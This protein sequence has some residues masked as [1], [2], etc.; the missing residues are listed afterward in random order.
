MSKRPWRTHVRQSVFAKF[1]AIMLT[2]A[3]SLLVLVAGFVLL[4]LRPVLNASI[5]PVL[6]EY[7][8][9]V[10]ATAPSYDTAKQLGARLDVQMRYEGPDGAWTTVAG[11]PTVA[12]TRREKGGSANGRHYYVA[13]GGN[14]GAYV[15]AWSFNQRMQTAHLVIPALLLVLM[16]AVIFAAHVVLRR[17]LQPLRWLG[18]GVAGLS[19][20][21]LDVSVPKRSA[22]EFGALTDAFNQMVGRIRDM[23]GARDRLL[24]DVSHE[25]RSPLT[26]LKVALELVGDVEMKA[27]MAAE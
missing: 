27:R 26:R 7:A 22:D 11:L 12:E 2:M 3:A 13:P 6:Q 25:L 9:V 5:D 23:I 21:H 4:Y 16:V 14:G 1:V 8:R 10:A 18:D 24:L 17:L 19:E 20:A 15:F